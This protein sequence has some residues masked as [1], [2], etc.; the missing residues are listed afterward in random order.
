M[1]IEAFTNR[2]ICPKCGGDRFTWLYTEESR[3]PGRVL[4]GPHLLLSCARCGYTFAMRTRE[5]K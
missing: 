2:P 1:D 5:Q 4:T 3:S